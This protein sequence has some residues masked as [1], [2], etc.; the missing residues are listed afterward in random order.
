MQL[1][2]QIVHVRDSESNQSTTT[3]LFASPELKNYLQERTPKHTE[4]ARGWQST[5]SGLAL[6]RFQ[7]FVIFI[8]MSTRP[9]TELF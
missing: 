7:M 3:G 4:V 1:T 8:C 5:L 2:L 9:H 6:V